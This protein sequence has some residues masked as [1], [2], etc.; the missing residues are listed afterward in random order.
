MEGG[1]EERDRRDGMGREGG[2]GLCRVT[3]GARPQ[4]ELGWGLQVYHLSYFIL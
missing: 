2:V 4:A 3:G 1:R